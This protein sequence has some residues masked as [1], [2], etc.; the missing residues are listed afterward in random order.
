MA[1]EKR[2]MFDI[3]MGPL[4]DNIFKLIR[5]LNIQLIRYPIEAHDKTNPNRFSALR[6]IR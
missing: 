3:G 4:E 2:R 5:N 6:L 1:K